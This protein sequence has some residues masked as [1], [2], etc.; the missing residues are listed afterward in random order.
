MLQIFKS[1]QDKQLTMLQQVEEYL[2]AKEFNYRYL[3]AKPIIRFG[4]RGQNGNWDTYIRTNDL[5]TVLTIQIVLPFTVSDSKKLKIADL[6]NRINCQLGFGKVFL[7]NEDGDI[8]YTIRHLCTSKLLGQ[9]DTDILFRTSF[10]TIDDL[11][12]VITS[13]CFGDAEP[14][15]AIQSFQ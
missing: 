6:L 7:D 4:L 3:D 15:L 1:K 14:S 9:E 2:T 11:I 5:Q 8:T 10:S 13:V 12:P